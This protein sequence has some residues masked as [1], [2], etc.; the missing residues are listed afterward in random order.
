MNSTRP[1]IQ[2]AIGY[3]RRGQAG[4]AA[5]FALD[6]RLGEIVA[7][8][9]DPMMGQ[10]R[11]TWWR[12]ALAALDTKPPPAEPILR[13]LAEHVLPQGVTGKALG[14]IT[15]AW[16]ALLEDP[17][18]VAA[19]ER[20]AGRGKALFET[21]GVVIG[22]RDPAVADAGQGWALADLA[23]HVSDPALTE[24]AARMARLHLDRALGHRWSRSGRTLGA[25]AL[26]ARQD[27][28][29]TNPARRIVRL[30]G[31]RLTGH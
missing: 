2:L 31:L 28:D 27:L 8:A 18:G 17:I 16:E 3:A 9:R 5:L 7:S 12:E 6:D 13:G 24:T 21:L 1:D 14:A 4:V 26:L 15:D 29:G 19:I 11:L 10:M 23:G 22:S 30:I 25:L 20:H